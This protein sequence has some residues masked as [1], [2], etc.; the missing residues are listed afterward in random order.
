[1][2]QSDQ[3]LWAVSDEFL[4]DIKSGD[5]SWKINMD[6]SWVLSIIMPLC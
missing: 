5:N 6:I 4:G 1:M 3:F 2:E